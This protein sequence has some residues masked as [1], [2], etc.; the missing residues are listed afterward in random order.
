MS[1]VGTFQDDKQVKKHGEAAASWYVGW[2]EPAGKKR[3]K[4]CG[5]GRDGKK[6]A[7][8]LAKKREAELIAGTYQSNERQIWAEFREEYDRKVLA[9]AGDRTKADTLHALAQFERLIKPKYMRAINSRT[10]SEFVAKREKERGLKK[11]SRV[12]P[13]TINKELR[14]LRAVI[15]RAV[16]W[17][18]IPKAPDFDFLREPEKLP[19]Y[20]PPEHFLKLYD[21]CDTMT[22]PGQFSFPAADWWRGLLMFA[23]MTG[24]R[25][26]S[27]LAA[28]WE[29]V[30]LEAGKVVSRFEDNKGRRDQSLPLHP[31]AQEHL[32]KL[33]SFN[34]RVFPWPHGRRQLFEAF[35]KL[36]KA[37]GVRPE[38]RKENYGFHDLRRAFATMNADRL[39]P[40][41][42]QS[43]MQHKD[44][45]T[46]QRYI[47]IARQLNPA[48]AN[49]F[50]PD[51]GNRKAGSSS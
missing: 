16:K 50:V 2:F 1:R 26:S 10:I 8:R 12:S 31:I 30:D 5:P 51:V 37:A 14:H 20:V 36:Q 3:C 35:N 43:L 48:V 21:A 15:R 41:A 9:I 24:W 44:Y 4:S 22:K 19:T 6:A 40:D 25:I 17:D 38:G 49:L 34:P 32:R 47:A 23:C 46:T 42:L 39:T 28:R 13:A 45:Q 29:D 11:E 33:V 27:I 18:Y 7:M